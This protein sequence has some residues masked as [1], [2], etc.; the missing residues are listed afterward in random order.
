MTGMPDLGQIVADA[1]EDVQLLKRTGNVGQAEYLTSLLD[2]IKESAED[3]LTWLSEDKSH[4]KS[5]LSYRT[6][7]RRFRE[8]YDCGLARY[9]AKGEREFRSCAIPQRPDA[10]LARAAGLAGE[11]VKAS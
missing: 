6:L 2:R 11:S 5:G 10:V 9:N 8:L 3:Y 4:I 7:R 1:R